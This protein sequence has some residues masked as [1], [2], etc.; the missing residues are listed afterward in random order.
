MTQFLAIDL[1]TT[2]LKGAVLNLEA[3]TVA[4]VR[5]SPVPEPIAGLPPGHCELD[6]ATLLA[7]VRD[8]IGALLADAPESTGLVMSSQMHCVVL[9][10]DAGRP[11][12]NIVTWKDGRALEPSP[13]G[14][15]VFD[16]LLRAVAPEDQARVGREL[17]VGT[18]AA[19]LFWLGQR[20]LLRAGDTPLSLPDFV[21]ADLCGT[22]PATH[23]TNAAAHGLFDLAHGDWHRDLIRRL[24][25]D[26]LRWPAI[27]PL[28]AVVGIAEI[29][30]R[31]LTCYAPVGDQQA[32]L[33]GVGV[34]DRELSINISTGSQIGLTGRDVPP[35]EYQVRPHFDGRQLRT[36][37]GVPA[38]RS[39]GVLV[40]LLTEL[41]RTAGVPVPDPWEAIAAAV[42]RAGE[43]ELDVNLAFF[44]S[45]VG[46]RGQIGNIRE[47]NLTVGGLFAAAFRGMADNYARFAVRLSPNREW[48]R[49]VFSGGV[50]AKF[51]RLRREIL[52]ALGDP[53]ARVSESDEDVL[54]GLLAVARV[55]AGLSATVDL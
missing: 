25:L 33:A 31:R 19:T 4:H 53:P 30:G 26:S 39:L 45:A 49:V 2:F 5:R 18:P 16:D 54:N 48:D 11:R 40:D 13:N 1:G 51:P 12:S 46:D 20:G 36:I 27:R 23:A 14:G 28:G 29:G 3:R 35:G 42:E 34:R 6:P 21:F 41:G 37:V 38:G 15:T 10:D 9:A 43:P 55:C 32:A 24:G 50:A 52:R 22:E 17:R 44:A 7:S 8:L 47:G